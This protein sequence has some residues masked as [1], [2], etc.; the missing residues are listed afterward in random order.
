MKDKQPSVAMNGPR[1]HLKAEAVAKEPYLVWNAFIDLIAL[2]E[3]E[4][5]SAVQRTA[6]LAFYYDAEVQNGGHHQYF[7]NSA[8]IRTQ[9]TVDALL[10]LGL[11]CQAE[12]L[13]QAIVTWNSKEREPAATPEEFLAGEL[14]GEFEGSDTSYYECS[15]TTTERLELYLAEHQSDFVIVEGAA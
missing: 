10:Q 2:E 14:E 11:P 12:I 13:R 6:Q 1:R 5:L 15:P 8:G 7:E 3:Y 4:A 9:E